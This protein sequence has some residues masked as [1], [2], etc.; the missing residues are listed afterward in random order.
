MSDA[1]PCAATILCCITAS[2]LIIAIP[3]QFGG[4]ERNLARNEA[5][6]Q[7]QCTVLEAIVTA[8]TCYK[9]CNCVQH[10]NR[11][12]YINAEY[13]QVC[14]NNCHNVCQSCPYECYSAA[15]RIGYSL[16]DRFGNKTGSP[17]ST[18]LDC[19]SGYPSVGWAQQELNARPVN[20]QFACYYDSTDVGT[21]L[22]SVYEIDGFYGSF[23]A[24]YVLAGVSGLCLLG[25]LAAAFFS[26]FAVCAS[27]CS[28][29]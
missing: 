20:S 19:G 6:V 28:P 21:V 29:V 24:F 9:S 17:L 7:T 27:C 2:M 18:I 10:C 22:L 13:K 3:L 11:S 26:Q 14:S 23:I 8:Y 5:L 15:W 1:L 4:Y 16:V 12:C 25:V